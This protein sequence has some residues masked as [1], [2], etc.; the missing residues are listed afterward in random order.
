MRWSGIHRR[1][2]G[3]PRVVHGGLRARCVLQERFRGRSA[4]AD[5]R[6]ARRLPDIH[7]GAHERAFPAASGCRHICLSP[8]T[9]I[10]KDFFTMQFTSLLRLVRVLR[11]SVVAKNL[12][13]VL[14][15]LVKPEK[16][17]K[18]LSPPP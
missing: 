6:L 12:V 18:T 7:V 14:R 11:E 4:A 3:A 13:T 10:V 17:K 15:D 2:E 5:P 1:G 9:S 8:F 16:L